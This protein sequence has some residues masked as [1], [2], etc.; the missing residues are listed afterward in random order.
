MVTAPLKSEGA[1]FAG[2]GAAVPDVAIV[3]VL[4]T[5]WG[6]VAGVACTGA[7]ADDAGTAIVV[8]VVVEPAA[9]VVGTS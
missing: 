6:V 1:G 5:G 2:L 4:A 7:V 3:A 8:T 9:V